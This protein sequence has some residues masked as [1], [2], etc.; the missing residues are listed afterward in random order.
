[1]W[2]TGMWERLGESALRCLPKNPYQETRWRGAI[3]HRLAIFGTV[4]KCV[5]NKTTLRVR[6]KR[7]PVTIKAVGKNDKQSVF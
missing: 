4:S 3:K 7:Q 6:W 2:K 1:M 5:V